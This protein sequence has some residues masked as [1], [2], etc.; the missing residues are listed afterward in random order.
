MTL[1]HFC[2]EKKKEIPLEEIL[3]VR[4]DISLKSH[5]FLY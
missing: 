5:K 3:K 1:M 2:L 4:K